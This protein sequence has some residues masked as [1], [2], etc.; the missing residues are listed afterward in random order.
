MNTID[1]TGLKWFWFQLRGFYDMAK[2]TIVKKDK[3]LCL[4]DLTKSISPL[5]SQ[6]KANPL[7]QLD[8]QEVLN[9]V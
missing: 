9:Q 5:E 6:T 4:T 2:R 7:V 1:S 3:T 8:K